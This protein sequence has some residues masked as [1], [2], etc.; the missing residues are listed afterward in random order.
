M[1]GWMNGRMDGRMHRHPGKELHNLKVVRAD[2]Q[3]SV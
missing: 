1:D 3:K 2:W